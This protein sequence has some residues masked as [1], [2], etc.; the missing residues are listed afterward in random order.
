[1]RIV[2]TIAY[3]RAG[4]LGNPSDGFFGRTLSV[5]LKNFAARVVLYEWP[6]LE[7]V[8]SRQDRCRFEQ[9]EDLAEDVRL[10]GLYGGLR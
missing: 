10:N 4:L 9:I 8:L 5:T 7:I 2:K 3:A 1:M 6:E